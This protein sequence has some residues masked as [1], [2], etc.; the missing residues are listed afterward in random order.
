MEDQAE[1]EGILAEVIGAELVCIARLVPIAAKAVKFLLGQPAINPFTAMTVLKGMM[2]V[3]SQED[4]EEIVA[5]GAEIPE[6]PI[7]EVKIGI[8]IETDKCM[9][10]PVP[11]AAKYAKCH[12]NRQTINLFTAI[13]ASRPAKVIALNLINRIN[14]EKNLSN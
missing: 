7:L 9:K 8:E 5:L 3:L 10:Q 11:N 4:P 1:A 13:I 2:A 14:P 6:D 12:L